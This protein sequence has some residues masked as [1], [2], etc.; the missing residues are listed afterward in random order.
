MLLI[1]QRSAV[2]IDVNLTTMFIVGL[3]ATRAFL[4]DNYWLHFPCRIFDTFV[5]NIMEQSTDCECYEDVPQH[6]D[7]KMCLPERT[8]C[9]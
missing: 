4:Q 1:V 3:L 6:T 2:R 9:A 8:L 5:N 7:T